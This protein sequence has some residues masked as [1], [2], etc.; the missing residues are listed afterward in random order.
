M[1]FLHPLKKKGTFCLKEQIPWVNWQHKL[2]KQFL[3]VQNIRVASFLNTAI[4]LETKHDHKRTQKL[5]TFFTKQKEIK[6]FTEIA[7][8]VLKKQN[9]WSNLNRVHTVI[10]E[11]KL[12]TV[13]PRTYTSTSSCPS[14]STPDLAPCYCSWW[15]SG[16]WPSARIP[17]I[18]VGDLQ[19][20]TRPSS[21]HYIYAFAE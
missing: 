21:G 18:H 5:G 12:S 4:Q 19:A 15:S 16:R 17:S 1:T 11:I 20:W 9:H 2:F 6:P 14:C 7:L 10:L 8:L 13:I 3:H